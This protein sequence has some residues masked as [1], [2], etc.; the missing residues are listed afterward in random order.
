M[1]KS[2][3]IDD[4]LDGGMIHREK[5]DYEHEKIAIRR[6]CGQKNAQYAA[7]VDPSCNEGR[8]I[9]RKT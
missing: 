3:D 2:E 5:E 7:W 1:Q 8:D 9:N 6:V 4:S